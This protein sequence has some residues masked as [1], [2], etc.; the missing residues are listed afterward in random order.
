LYLSKV[1]TDLSC[2]RPIEHLRKYHTTMTSIRERYFDGL[3]LREAPILQEELKTP[4]PQSDPKVIMGEWMR[5]FNDAIQTKNATAVA[6][7]F[8]ED[9]CMFK[10]SSN[11]RMV[12]RYT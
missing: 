3:T 8:R 4:K 7:L 10:N 11:A 9:G 6:S 2:N 5:E 1:L 12:E